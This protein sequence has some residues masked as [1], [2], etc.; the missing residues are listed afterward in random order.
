VPEASQSMKIKTA[1]LSVVC[2]IAAFTNAQA[3]D[4]RIEHMFVSS[5]GTASAALAAEDSNVRVGHPPIYSLGTSSDGFFTPFV[6]LPDPIY[7]QE[8]HG[9]SWFH[10]L[11]PRW[12]DDRFLVFEDKSGIA[13]ADV[14]NRRLLVDHVFTAYEKSPVA[15][16]WVAIRFRA[17]DRHQ[18][19]LSDDFQDTVLMID[20]YE[21]ANRIGAATEANF[22]GQ[23]RAVNP[24]GIVLAK[25]EWAPDGST[26][27][28][29]IWN[30]GTV[31]AVRYDTNLNETG[32]TR[33]DLQVDRE[34]ALS[35]S[36]NAKLAQTAKNILSD[37]TIFH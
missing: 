15:D 10:G 25:P 33:V 14:Q 34:S 22:V 32:R 28:V 24:G 18:P 1:V 29:L 8:C 4:Y 35:L 6:E 2:G 20:P 12:I 13:I 16:K 27:A 5:S 17:T 36:L 11:Q 21:V 23:M 9:T 3:G 31:E 30:R 37:P 26:F 7:R 19:E